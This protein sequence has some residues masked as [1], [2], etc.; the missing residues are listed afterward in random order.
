M[1]VFL[2]L[3]KTDKDEQLGERSASQAHA[4][5]IYR[6]KLLTFCS[7]YQLLFTFWLFVVVSR[8]D[9]PFEDVHNWLQ[10]TLKRRKT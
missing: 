4:N 6:V 7:R 1:D 9:K 10:T 8:A 3:N 5:V 2:K